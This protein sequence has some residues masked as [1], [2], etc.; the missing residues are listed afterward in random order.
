MKRYS[1]KEREAYRRG[2][3][4]A[5]YQNKKKQKRAPPC[6]AKQ[7]SKPKYGNYDANAAFKRA[8]ERTYGPPIKDD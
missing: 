4:I 2:K 1:D 8:L 5:Y 6:S 3:I 7:P